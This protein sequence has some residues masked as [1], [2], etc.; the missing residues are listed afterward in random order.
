MNIPDWVLPSVL[1]AL[2]VPTQVACGPCS[3]RSRVAV[4]QEGQTA[5]P[6][7]AFRKP[8]PC[9]SRPVWLDSSP[10]VLL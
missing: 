3:G 8:E 5:G 1:E 4:G 7:T 6:V 9:L 10:A 2:A